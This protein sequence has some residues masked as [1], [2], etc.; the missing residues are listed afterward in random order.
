MHNYKGVHINMQSILLTLIILAF[1]S[2]TF[3]QDQDKD[4]KSKE[5]PKLEWRTGKVLD[6]DGESYTTYG[7]TTTNGTVNPNGT[8][9]A[10]TNRASWNH[11]IYRYTIAD[12][13]YIYVVSRI[14][15]F[16]W[17]KE[18][19]LTV[20]GPVRFAIKKNELV[21]IDDNGRKMSG[22]ITKRVLKETPAAASQPAG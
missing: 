21:F 6:T 12:E 11:S 19:V 16:R 8:F 9:N 17:E 4:A 15:S 13:K 18:A 10:T 22:R 20:N 7:G 3:A 5:D 14:L 2:L 1:A